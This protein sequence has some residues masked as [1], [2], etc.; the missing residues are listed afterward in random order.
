MHSL[1]IVILGLL[2]A[3]GIAYYQWKRE[4]Q[5]GIDL[6]GLATN[7]GWRYNVGKDHSFNSQYEHGLF[8][9]GHDQFAR[10]VLTGNVEIA[11]QSFPITMG[12]YQF[13]TG[14][15]KNQ[16]IHRM[17][18]MLL[19]PPYYPLPSLR[20]GREG[21]GGR[22]LDAFGFDDIDF[23][24]EE[25][26]RKYRV[27]SSNKKFAYAVIHAR[28]IDFL[29]QTTP[30]HIELQNGV[31]LF[32]EGTGR[33]WTPS[34]FRQHLAWARQFFALWPVDMLAELEFLARPPKAAS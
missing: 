14:S 18:L 4:Q 10:H 13:T 21:I 12:D 24:S 26:S 27:N 29:L 17:S 19:S 1:P 28:M 9:K 22:L 3:G 5:R 25:F 2:A 31:C 6:G 7:L 33:E 23:E 20:I 8:K 16:Q 34:V 15:G 11:K 32:F 30:P